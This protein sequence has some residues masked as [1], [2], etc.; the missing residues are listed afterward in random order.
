MDKRVLAASPWLL[1]IALLSA[2]SAQ[3][4]AQDSNGLDCRSLVTPSNTVFITCSAAPE[5]ATRMFWGRSKSTVYEDLFRA[6]GN[7]CSMHELMRPI[8]ESWPGCSLHKDRTSAKRL[9]DSC[10][11]FLEDDLGTATEVDVCVITTPSAARGEAVAQAVAEISSKTSELPVAEIPRDKFRLAERTYNPEPSD[12]LGDFNWRPCIRDE[13]GKGQRDDCALGFAVHIKWLADDLGLS[14][15]Q[16]IDTGSHSA[17]E[18]KVFEH[19][20]NGFSVNVAR[21]DLVLADFSSQYR[22]AGDLTLATDRGRGLFQPRNVAAEKCD[23]TCWLPRS[24]GISFGLGGGKTDSKEKDSSLLV[25]KSGVYMDLWDFF[26]VEGGHLVAVALSGG[27]DDRTDSAVYWGLRLETEE[28]LDAAKALL[29]LAK[30]PKP[31]N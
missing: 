5:G 26:G 16:A 3:A 25:V 28:A 7:P 21:A 8:S 23:R 29:K 12:F 27:F 18:V 15:M 6:D 20:E 2:G 31:A 10:K 14:Y 11:V 19:T 24:L 30:R 4:S 17:D 9:P 13:R 1:S 22:R